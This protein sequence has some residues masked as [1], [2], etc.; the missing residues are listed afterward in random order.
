MER[1]E[2][3]MNS[4]SIDSLAHKFAELSGKPVL[5]DKDKTKNS[6]AYGHPQQTLDRE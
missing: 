6:E 4:R 5:L 2:D 3:L 1:E